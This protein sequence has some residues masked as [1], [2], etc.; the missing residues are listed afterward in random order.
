MIDALSIIGFVVTTFLVGAFAGYELRSARVAREALHD[1]R[2]ALNDTRGA[3]VLPASYDDLKAK[4]IA[5]ELANPND[6]V[7]RCMQLAFAKAR[8]MEGR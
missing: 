5:W 8:V 6:P 4:I 7:P 2:R 3:D 1:A